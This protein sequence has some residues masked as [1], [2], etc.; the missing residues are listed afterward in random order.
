MPDIC[1]CHQYDTRT[2]CDY[3]GGCTAAGGCCQV[4]DTHC[5]TCRRRSPEPICIACG[6]RAANQ[7]AEFP[8]LVDRL[9]VEA[10]TRPAGMREFVSGAGYESRPPASFDAMVLTAWTTMAI[11]IEITDP[12]PPDGDSGLSIPLWVTAWAAVWRHRWGH[13]Q[14]AG[15]RG[16]QPARTT[17]APADTDSGRLECATSRP[18]HRCRLTD[19]PPHMC[20]H[21]RRISDPIVEAETHTPLEGPV[22]PTRRDPAEYAASV[23]ARL[24]EQSRD[25]R[26][27]AR[28]MLGLQVTRIQVKHGPEVDK[29]DP[30]VW[31]RVDYDGADDGLAEHWRLRFGDAR[32]VRRFMVDLAYLATWL[33]RGLAEMNDADQFVIGLRS[34]IG[35]GRAAIGERSDVVRLGRCPEMLTD[36]ASGNEEPC[37][38][39]LARDPMV[40]IVICPRCR[41]E[42]PEKGLLALAGRMH[43]VYGPI[44]QD[45]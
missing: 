9:A 11:G 39:W 18:V 28:V 31:A 19:L 36:R 41:T 33:D 12:Q 37:G 40:S 5:R 15:V 1:A 26:Y 27:M 16:P 42:T 23:A 38:A 25:T 7:L 14:P 22:I 17:T 20:A 2:P 10:V 3:P 43:H 32:Q 29:A 21:C 44:G 45:A 24:E 13:H 34:L 4:D 6:N 8:S 35:A 30:T